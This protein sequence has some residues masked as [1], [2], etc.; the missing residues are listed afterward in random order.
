MNQPPPIT[1]AQITDEWIGI[2]REIVSREGRAMRLGGL[3]PTIQFKDLATNVWRN[4]E[5]PGGGVLFADWTERN[6]VAKRL[7]GR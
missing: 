5:L 3:H 7:E 2:V 4:I 6:L 1:S